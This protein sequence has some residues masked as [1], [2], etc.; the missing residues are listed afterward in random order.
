MHSTI[1]IWIGLILL[2]TIS[3]SQCGPVDEEESDEMVLDERDF[4]PVARREHAYGYEALLKRLI[5]Q[6][7][8]LSK[9]PCV[10]AFANKMYWASHGHVMDW[11][12]YEP[13]VE[14][15]MK[16]CDSLPTCLS[17]AWDSNAGQYHR[18]CG[19]YS[20][21][22]SLID[23]PGVFG[24]A[25][26]SSQTYSTS[27]SCNSCGVCQRGCVRGDNINGNSWCLTNSHNGTLLCSQNSDCPASGRCVGPCRT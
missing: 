25:C 26:G 17:W 23:R 13:N 22:G 18:R 12:H 24:G 5:I 2:G 27:N 7:R 19:V 16:Y 15:C 3:I 20:E 10:E 11:S 14:A 4:V 9:K 6:R 1:S 8:T 21:I